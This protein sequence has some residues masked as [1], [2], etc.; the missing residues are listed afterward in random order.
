MPASLSP[1][2]S[3]LWRMVKEEGMSLSQAITRCEH[4]LV[5]AALRAEGNN[6]TRAA[7]RLG[8]HVRT[9]FKKLA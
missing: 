8:I 9:I 1:L 4:L 2:E 5:Q 3:E 7:S 6:R